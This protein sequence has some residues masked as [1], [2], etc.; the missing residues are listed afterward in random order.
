MTVLINISPTVLQSYVVHKS[1]TGFTIFYSV[2]S[3]GLS[4]LFY[5]MTILSVRT[6]FVSLVSREVY[7][8]SYTFTVNV[9]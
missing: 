7:C 1:M 6:V 8:I 9:C 4:L 3:L 2:L 5:I